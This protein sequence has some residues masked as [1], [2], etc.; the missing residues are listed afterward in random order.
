MP[1]SFSKS[2]KKEVALPSSE[3]EL[4]RYVEQLHHLYL[5]DYD[6]LYDIDIFPSDVVFSQPNLLI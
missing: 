4:Y 1:D 6:I 5:W 3:K 2:S